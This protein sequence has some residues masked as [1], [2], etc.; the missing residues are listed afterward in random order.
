VTRGL[1]EMG[2]RPMEDPLRIPTSIVDAYVLEP[3]VRADERGWVGELVRQSWLSGVELVQ[4][5]IVSSVARTLR[6][7]HWHE[8]HHDLISPVAGR[9]LVGLADLREGSKT[10][11]VT[12]LLELDASRPAAI[13][14]PPGVAHGLYSREPTTLLYAVSRYW[15]PA[16][17]FGVAFDDPELGVAW[18]CGRDDVVLSQRDRALPLL[19]SASSLAERSAAPA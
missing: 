13:V 14:I 5:N 12:E 15:D 9:V 16:D 10:H 3:P 2:T 19:T 1:V 18:P 17:E 4:W 7:M 6:G 11:R 8:Q